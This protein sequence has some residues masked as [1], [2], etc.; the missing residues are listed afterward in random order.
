MRCPGSNVLSHASAVQL[1]VLR[2]EG[3]QWPGVSCLGV[4]EPTQGGP[5]FT[6]LTK[7][8]FFAVSGKLL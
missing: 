6:S 3:A 8:E 1:S 7:P 2:L 5:G 4:I